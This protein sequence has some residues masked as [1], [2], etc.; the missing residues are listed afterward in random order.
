M[1]SEYNPPH[2]VFYIVRCLKLNDPRPVTDHLTYL[3]YTMNKNDLFQRMD[4]LQKLTVYPLPES[5]I[6]DYKSMYILVYKL[7]D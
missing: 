1:L 4:M 6:E 5:L 2:T 7:M 3:H